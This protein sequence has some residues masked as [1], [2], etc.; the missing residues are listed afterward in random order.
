MFGTLGR[1]GE[2]KGEDELRIGL[3][4][5]FIIAVNV[6]TISKLTWI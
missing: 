6:P 2:N 3:E 1:G 4:R 5:L